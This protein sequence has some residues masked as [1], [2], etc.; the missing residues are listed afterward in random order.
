MEL[1]KLAEEESEMYPFGPTVALAYQSVLNDCKVHC[2][3]E[4]VEVKKLGGLHVIGT[5]LH[6]SRRIDN[7]VSVV[8]T[9]SG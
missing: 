1:R 8:Q 3:N 4:G 2:L 7:Q 9:N 6:D 5:S